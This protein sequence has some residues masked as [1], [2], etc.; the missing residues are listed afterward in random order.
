MM[1]NDSDDSNT[2]TGCA[3]CIQF[4]MFILN[5]VVIT[6]TDIDTF[7]D[8]G[9]KLFYQF[10]LFNLIMLAV[11][12]GY[13]IVWTLGNIYAIKHGSTITP[14]ILN[15][16]YG[17]MFV[18]WMVIILYYMGSIWHDDPRHSI[19]FY[20]EYWTESAI[21]FN[22]LNVTQLNASIPT[23]LRNGNVCKVYDKKWAYIM[24]DVV[25]RIYSFILMCIFSIILPIILI[26]LCGGAN[27][28]GISVTNSNPQVN[29]RG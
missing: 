18:T 21:N 26:I 3:P 29:L 7:Q 13:L 10:Q 28:K 1:M 19:M 25:I 20:N 23:S 8:L 2:S 14:K 12:F 15:I 4:I 27:V 11:L 6:N 24:S 22:C 5:V 17:M 16:G 9:H